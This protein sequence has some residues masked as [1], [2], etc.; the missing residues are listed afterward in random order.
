MNVVR[1]R[2]PVRLLVHEAAYAE[3]LA[4]FARCSSR[5]Q[6]VL[7]RVETLLRLLDTAGRDERFAGRQ[8]GL[9]G[10]G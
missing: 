2:V 4:T 1:G 6:T 9:D 5:I 7:A 8:I 10:V 3:K